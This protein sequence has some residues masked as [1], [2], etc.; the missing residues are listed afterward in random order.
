MDGGLRKGDR[1]RDF[2]GKNFTVSPHLCPKVYCDVTSDHKP[3]KGDFKGR[4]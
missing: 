4:A 1:E 2:F 3:S